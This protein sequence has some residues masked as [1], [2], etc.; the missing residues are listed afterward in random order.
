MSASPQSR[1]RGPVILDC[2]IR[3]GSYAIDFNFTAADTALIAGLLDKIGVRFVEIGH[4]LGLGAEK[5][6]RVVHDSEVIRSAL[7]CVD[8]ARLGAFFI[9]G[10]GSNSDL[11]DAAAAGLHFVRIGANADGID[12]AWSSIEHARELGLDVF[13][14]FMKTYGI[15]P[16]EFAEKSRQAAGL[17]VIGSYV[18][19]SAG[20]ML[21]GEVAEYVRAARSESD[22]AVGFHGHSNLHLA[23][24]NSLAA[25]EAGATFV[26]T[27]LYGIGR[28]S[29][30]VPTEVMAAVFSRAGI[31]CGVDA[32]DAIHV[33]DAYLKPLADHLHPHTMTS[34]ALGY[35]RFHSSFL[36]R[37]LAAAEAA[38]VDPLALVVALGTADPM[39]LSDELLDRTVH[40]LADSRPNPQSTELARFQ[41]EG[42]ER[43]RIVNRPGAAADLVDR[44][45][46]TASK[47]NLAVGLDLV[48]ASWLEPDTVT[49]EFV[50]EDEFAVLGRLRYGSRAALDEA[51]AD[52]RAQLDL[53]LL[54]VALLAPTE[55][56]EEL[57]FVRGLG[58]SAIA[59]NSDE[60]VLELLS[61]TACASI[62]AL[63]PSVVVVVNSGSYPAVMIDDLVR[64]LSSVASSCRLAAGADDC[65]HDGLVVAAGPLSPG[66]HGSAS[67]S[68]EDRDDD[69]PRRL[70][71][72]IR[73]ADAYRNQY[74]RWRQ[75]LTL[76]PA[77]PA[78]AGQ[79]K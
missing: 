26:D 4:G 48:P 9:P 49:S 52:S 30:N 54:D 61:Q 69:S 63:G 47:R 67:L 25:Y 33:A 60:L 64:R 70:Q 38:Q 42:F 6:K 31:D 14:N 57:D 11:Q 10:I 16:A 74:P 24:A 65:P 19:D 35:G 22:I 66:E 37:A 17:G 27:S 72:A 75:V 53:A 28:S 73:R 7:E 23:V 8:D 32:M 51:L 46:V 56:A 41:R 40:S 59:Y 58:V 3:D 18:V 79:S 39:N 20:G 13:V 1:R 55:R 15:S 2:T 68:I 50:A 36:D 29:G 78:V 44:L 71:R 62:A 43:L 34:V 45:S 76:A 12:R 5:R 21:P 77:P